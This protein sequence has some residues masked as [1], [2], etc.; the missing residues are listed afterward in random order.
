ME[1]FRQE[2][3]SESVKLF[4]Q[5]LEL[6]P[7]FPQVYNFMAMAKKEMGADG[8][9]VIKLLEKAVELDPNYAL[10]HDNLGAEKEDD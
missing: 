5:T 10:A 4:E 7:D 1:A 3:Y 2:K 9:E 6:Y 8:D